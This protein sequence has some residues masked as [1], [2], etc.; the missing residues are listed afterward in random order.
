[1]SNYVTVP[2]AAEILRRSRD[3]GIICHRRPDGDTLGSAYA[4]WACL[5]KMGIR[6]RILCCDEVTPNFSVLKNPYLEKADESFDPLTYI[7]VDVASEK[8]MGSYE[9]LAQRCVLCIDHHGSNTRYAQNL[10]LD[11]GAAACC[12][13]IWD[14]IACLGVEADGYIAAAVYIGVSTDTGCFRFRNTT[15]RTHEV[16]AETMRYEFGVGEI[17]NRLFEQKSRKMLALEKAALDS[18]EFFFDGAVTLITLTSE[19]IAATGAG[20]EEFD[21]ISAFART[22]E[23]VEVGVTIRQTG[24]DSYKVSVRSRNVDSAAICAAFGG[25]GHHG[26]AGCDVAGTRL[27]ELK[28]RLL[29]EIGK[30]L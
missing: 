22:I 24:E 1:M 28:T 14:V 18:A 16:A 12:E 30:S 9:P 7:A 17:N 2:E 23:G 25:G 29:E 8:M 11:P 21:G 3:V 5:G 4:L 15:R 20:P 26:A 27:D 6:S 10:L 19:T 13:I